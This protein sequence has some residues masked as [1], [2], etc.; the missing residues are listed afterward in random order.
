M[1][2]GSDNGT[3]N[4][5]V[6]GFGRGQDGELYVLTSENF[7]PAGNSGTVFKIVP[8]GA[9][10]PLPDASN[11]ETSETNTTETSTEN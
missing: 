9:G 5:Y 11:A 6:L 7:R 2:A 3:L 1:I 8:E 10:E 4:R